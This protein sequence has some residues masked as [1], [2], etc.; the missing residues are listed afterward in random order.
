LPLR[1]LQLSG[2]IQPE[3]NYLEWLAGEDGELYRYDVQVRQAAGWA[4]VESKQS[5]TISGNHSYHYIHPLHDKLSRFYRIAATELSIN[6]TIYS[7]TIMLNRINEGRNLMTVYSDLATGQVSVQL[8]GT[9]G[10]ITAKIYTISGQLVQQSNE[11]SNSFIL[12]I[13]R[14][15]A[16]IYMLRV[17]DARNQWQQKITRL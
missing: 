5:G 10:T 1:L 15:P 11:R 2:R 13:R 3:G 14:L 6:K 4:A 12:D 7:N 9:D 8:T 17:A 16:G